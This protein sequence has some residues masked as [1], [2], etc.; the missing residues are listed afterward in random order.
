CYISTNMADEVQCVAELK[1]IACEAIDKSSQDLRELSKIWQNPELNFKEIKS[2]GFLTEF[3]KENSFHVTPSWTLETAFLAKYGGTEGP[4]VG[5]ICE[6]DALPSVGHACGHNLISEAGAGAAIGIQAALNKTG[7]KLGKLHVLGTPAEEGG[8]GKL[9]MINNGCFNDVDF[10]M[11]VHPCP[12]DGVCVKFLRIKKVFV[13]FKG[14][15]AHAAAFPWEGI[16]ALDAAVMTYSSINSMRQQMKPQWRVHGVIHEGGVKP[17][18][19]P[20]RSRM[21][22]YLRTPNNKDMEVLVAKVTACFEAAAKATGCTHEVEWIES[23]SYMDMNINLKL[24]DLY[25]SNAQNLGI[26]FLSQEEEA[27][28]PMG[29][30]DMGNVS[31]TVPSIHPM[32][33]I[34]TT[35]PNHSH[36]FTAA[37]A[38]DAAHEKTLIAAKALAMTAI[39]VMSNPDTLKL[40]KE[41]FKESFI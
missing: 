25:R 34:D 33:G 36:G 30:T 26:K 16:N 13:T 9:F 39:D 5:I 35:A 28:L 12:Y 6:Y 18:I 31:Y 7:N 21:E 19:I 4:C 1:K 23:A 2:H 27:N 20:D 41:Q 10:S 11:M 37:A 17:N 32:Y 22:Y 15:A 8:G 38:T 14:F 40:I 29:S 3:F 24:A